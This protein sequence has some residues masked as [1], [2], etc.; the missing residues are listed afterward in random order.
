MKLRNGSWWPILFIIQSFIL[1][2]FFLLFINRRCYDEGIYNLWNCNYFM[3]LRDARCF[4]HPANICTKPV[5]RITAI[6]LYQENKIKSSASCKISYHTVYTPKRNLNF[7]PSRPPVTNA[8]NNNIA[9]WKFFLKIY[10]IPSWS[11][12]ESV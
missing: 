5:P 4:A 10:C 7:L 6:I 9:S 12:W 8:P 2:S 3:R 11:S 1:R